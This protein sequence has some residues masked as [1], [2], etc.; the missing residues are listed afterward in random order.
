MFLANEHC[1]DMGGWKARVGGCVI[2]WLMSWRARRVGGTG[3]L[4]WSAGWIVNG[5]YSGSV[6]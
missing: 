6:W 5:L 2:P 4:Q 3:M 1:I